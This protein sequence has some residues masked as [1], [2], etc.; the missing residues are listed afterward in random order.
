MDDLKNIKLVTMQD[1]D[2]DCQF[3]VGGSYMRDGQDPL[4]ITSIKLQ[5]DVPSQYCNTPRVCIYHV[6]ELLAEIPYP[7]VTFIGYF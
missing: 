5:I 2:Q 3:K 7:A 4:E 1:G 6:D